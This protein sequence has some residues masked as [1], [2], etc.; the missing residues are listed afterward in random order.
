MAGKVRMQ[1]K[2]RCAR[3]DDMLLHSLDTVKVA[4]CR[5]GQVA[6]YKVREEG[7]N[8]SSLYT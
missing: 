4:L 3:G 8:A 1:K 2:L 6:L 7:L 5:C